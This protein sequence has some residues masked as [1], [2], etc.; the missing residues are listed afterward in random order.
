MNICIFKALT[1]QSG[2]NLTNKL[3]GAEQ[4]IS[5]TQK[6]IIS[7]NI[8]TASHSLFIQITTENNFIQA[9]FTH[10]A[11]YSLQPLADC[12]PFHYH[13]SII[14]S[15]ASKI[16][17]QRGGASNFHLGTSILA[18]LAA[19]LAEEK[20]VLQKLNHVVPQE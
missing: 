18:G 8:Q 17:V 2:G 3:N 11:N 19:V 7:C 16:L 14:T 6:Q 13:P 20:K 9:L 12:P 15:F 5:D 10:L 4:I 1:G